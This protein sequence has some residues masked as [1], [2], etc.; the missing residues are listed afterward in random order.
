MLNPPRRQLIFRWEGAAPEPRPGLSS[1]HIP[2]S[3]P[4]P[5]LDYLAPP[6]DGKPYTSFK[7]PAELKEVLV[8][9]VG[10]KDTWNAMVKGEKNAVFTCGSGMTAAV[11]WLANEVIRREEGSKV[12]TSIYDEVSTHSPGIGAQL[13]R[14]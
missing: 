2:N 6:A 12:K 9:A 5:F 13:S 3:L 11:G 10:G 8:N 1:G 7:S 4:A 14:I